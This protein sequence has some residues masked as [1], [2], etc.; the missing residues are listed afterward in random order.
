M[1]LVYLITGGDAS[2][3]VK[4]QPTIWANGMQFKTDP[5]DWHMHTNPA[6]IG[7]RIGYTQVSIP[8][9]SIDSIRIDWEFPGTDELKHKSGFLASRALRAD[10]RH[11]PGHR[12]RHC[13]RCN[14]AYG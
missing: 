13:Q 12:C 5:N 11:W 7:V 2:N 8:Y 14:F 6:L 1:T 10:D 4:A 3:P 9:S